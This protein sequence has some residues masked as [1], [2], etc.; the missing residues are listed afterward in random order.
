MPPLDLPARLY[1][2]CLLQTRAPGW[3]ALTRRL[4]WWLLLC[5]PAGWLMALGHRRDVARALRDPAAD[6]LALRGAPLTPRGDLHRLAHGLGALGVLAAYAAPALLCAWQWGHARPLAGL[7]SAGAWLDGGLWGFLG[8]SL[9]LPPLTL[10]GVTAAWALS[11]SCALTP[12]GLAAVQGLLA[13]AVGLL[14][15][16]YLQVG[17]RGRWR[18]ALR[19][20]RALASLAAHPRAYLRA[21]GEGLRLSAAALALGARAP[22]GVVWS[23]S[24]IVWL[25]N[26]AH[27]APA[28]PLSA[29][30]AAPT[31]SAHLAASPTPLLWRLGRPIP[32]WRAAPTEA[33]D[34]P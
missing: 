5:P 7:L 15:A 33:L 17:A 34:V 14:P 12:G 6:P 25:F 20:H 13:L 24:A 31:L 30:R 1:L 8:A 26:E 22:W 16:A 10:G 3:A 11:D 2:P 32:D 28:H 19:P 18:D 21:W 4:G 9:A 27:L 29:A 23:Y